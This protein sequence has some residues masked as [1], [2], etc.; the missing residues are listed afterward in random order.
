MLRVLLVL[1]FALPPLAIVLNHDVISFV[2]IIGWTFAI[3]PLLMLRAIDF[4]RSG[5]KSSPAWIKNVMR[6]PIAL[7]GIL[8]FS[9]GLA[10]VAW[11]LYNV[12]IQRMPEYSG[13]SDAVGLWLSGFGIAPVL[14]TFGWYLLRLSVRRLNEL[15]D[16]KNV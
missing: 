1:L 13:P 12:V 10:I 15:G 9:I 4:F 5:E 16:E 11:C 6:V 8:S 14:L 3:I 2:L 7:L